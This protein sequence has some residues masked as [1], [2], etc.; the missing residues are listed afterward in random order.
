MQI[1]LLICLSVWAFVALRLCVQG[2]RLLARRRRV[3][4]LSRYV[5]SIENFS[6]GVGLAGRL[7]RCR[8][9]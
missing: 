5:E 7:A 2:V 1:A 9:K 4:A 6:P 3:L 8:L